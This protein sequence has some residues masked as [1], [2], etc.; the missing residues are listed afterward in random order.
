MLSSSKFQL[1][2][3]KRWSKISWTVSVRTSWSRR[4]RWSYI[5]CKN[6]R[7]ILGRIMSSH[8]MNFN[9]HHARPSE[10]I[11]FMVSL[12]RNNPL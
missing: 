9:C 5:P 12:A 7:K 11:L 4:E 8:D 6:A 3:K 2:S 10:R 1:L